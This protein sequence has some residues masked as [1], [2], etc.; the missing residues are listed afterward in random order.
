MSNKDYDVDT[1]VNEYDKAAN[2]A[3]FIDAQEIYYKKQNATDCADAVYGTD[4]NKVMA[5]LVLMCNEALKAETGDIDDKIEF[6]NRAA[7]F[8]KILINDYARENAELDWERR[9]D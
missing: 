9:N 7:I 8:A 6:T 5:T 2:R 1:C 3:E 4:E